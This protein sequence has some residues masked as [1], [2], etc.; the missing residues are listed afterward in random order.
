MLII[1]IHKVL[2][3]ILWLDYGNGGRLSNR[4]M[5]VLNVFVDAPAQQVRNLTIN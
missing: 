5:I 3:M 4:S 1:T 2:R